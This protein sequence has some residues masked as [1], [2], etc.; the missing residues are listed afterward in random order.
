M[1]TVLVALVVIALAFLNFTA[2]YDIVTGEPDV[3]GEWAVVGASGLFAAWSL[4]RALH[5]R[6][7]SE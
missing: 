3:R 1:R 5:R 2:I 4:A 6:S 7:Q